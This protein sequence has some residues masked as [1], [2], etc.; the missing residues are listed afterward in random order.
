MTHYYSITAIAE[1]DCA[2]QEH[3]VILGKGFN[4]F[5]VVTTDIEKLI[6]D[7]RAGGVEVRQVNCLDDFHE[8]TNG[9]TP[10]GLGEGSN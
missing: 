2:F 6:A 4:V 1:D 3:L 5:T 10:L 7:L 9:T 8:F